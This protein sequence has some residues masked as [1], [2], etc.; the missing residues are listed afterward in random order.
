MQGGVILSI[1]FISSLLILS[2]ITFLFLYIVIFIHYYHTW[3]FIFFEIYYILVL[4]SVL[5][6]KVLSAESSQLE[7][8]FEN[9]SI[10]SLRNSWNF[11]I[12][13]FL[14]F[15]IQL[16]LMALYAV[17]Y[18]SYFGYFGTVLRLIKRDILL[19]FTLDGSNLPALKK[20]SI[21]LIKIFFNTI[22]IL[23]C[24]LFLVSSYFNLSFLISL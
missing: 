9:I 12:E 18:L 20:L 24:I 16:K 4:Y 3:I 11:L 19:C 2:S 22:P 5:V 15:S 10:Y 6:L 8:F 21:N 7:T 1:F 23:D 13:C 17:W 14:L